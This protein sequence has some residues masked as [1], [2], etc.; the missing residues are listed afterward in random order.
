MWHLLNG[1]ILRHISHA[2]IKWTELIA[3]FVFIELINLYIN[4]YIYSSIYLL[5]Y[6]FLNLFI[7]LFVGDSFSYQN[8][9]RFSAKDMDVDGSTGSNCAQDFKGAWW[10]GACHRSN[11]NGQYLRGN[12]ITFADGVNWEHWLGQQYSLKKT[13]MKIRPI[14]WVNSFGQIVK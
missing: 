9:F 7:N 5:I 11:L 6:L 13:V 12:H 8:G 3:I 10:Y 2:V 4:K 14:N 1:C